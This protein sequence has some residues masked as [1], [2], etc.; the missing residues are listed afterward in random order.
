M[1]IKLLSERVRG[2]E[3]RQ[4]DGQP[5]KNG[6]HQTVQDRGGRQTPAHRACHAI[7]GRPEVPTGSR[8]FRQRLNFISANIVRAPSM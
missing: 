5:A 7:A 1:S 4:L 3:A 6:H 2:H 8:R